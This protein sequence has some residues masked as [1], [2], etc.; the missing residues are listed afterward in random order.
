MATAKPVSLMPLSLEDRAPAIQVS[1]STPPLVWPVT[2]CVGTA[3]PL[4]APTVLPAL[5]VLP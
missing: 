1:S 2:C 3:L 4:G 5:Q